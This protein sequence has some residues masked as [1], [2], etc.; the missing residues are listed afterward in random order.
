MFLA[1]GLSSTLGIQWIFYHGAATGDSYL[2]QLAQF[3]GMIFVG[4]LIP[5]LKK[6][7]EKQYNRIPQQENDA[8]PMSFVNT[9]EDGSNYI[10]GP[11]QHASVIKLAIL[12][13]LANSCVTLGFSIIGSGMYQVIY[14]SV[15]IWCAILTF[16]IM[17]KR[18]STLQWIAIFGT[19]AGLALSSLDSMSDSREEAKT[20]ILMFGTLMT[21]GGTFFYSCAY[22]YSDFIMS[23]QVPPPLPARVCCYAGMYASLISLLWISVYTLP[24]YDQL[25]HIKPGTSHGQVVQVYLLVIASNSLHSW[26]YYELIDR[27]GS[28]ATGILQGLRAVLIYMLSDALYCKTDSA[29]CFTPYKGL[30]SILVV[31]SVMLF[32][33]GGRGTSKEKQHNAQD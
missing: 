21:L 26:N 25:I 31:G 3:V 13:V 28:V 12:D 8:I 10:E 22:V 30:G 18:L 4:L 29:Q 16:L 23:K 7:K 17:N 20:G 6:K 15:V 33:I 32:T 2:T 27:T 9:H 1:T 24:R 5:T 11:I 14:S 19:S